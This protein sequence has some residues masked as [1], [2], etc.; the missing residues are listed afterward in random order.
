MSHFL[1]GLLLLFQRFSHQSC[2]NAHS[3]VHQL[4]WTIYGSTE[5]A[6]WPRRFL[7]MGLL[8]L[9]PG[10]PR[11]NQDRGHPG[12]TSGLRVSSFLI[13]LSVPPSLLLNT[14]HPRFLLGHHF[15]SLH[16]A[17]YLSLRGA[18]TASSPG[19]DHCIVTAAVSPSQL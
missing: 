3:S 14:S 2:G 18:V 9:K 12:S 17:V 1:F 13:P 6:Q 16:G 19:S 8:V 5:K 4:Y 15:C 10:Q 7:D 11:A